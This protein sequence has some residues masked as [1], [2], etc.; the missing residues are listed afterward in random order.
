MSQEIAQIGL[1]LQALEDE[2]LKDKTIVII[3]SDHGFQLGKH[4]LWSKYTLFEQT[5]R[6]LLLILISGLT[7]K[8]IVCD[9][10]LEL[11]VLLPTLCE[12]LKM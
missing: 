5:T 11:V 2:W 4:D 6:V 12:L 10:I 1:I 7:G 3:F 8:R 9:E